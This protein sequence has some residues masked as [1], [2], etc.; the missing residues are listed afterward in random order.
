M[1]DVAAFD[2]DGTL[3]DGGSVLE[4]LVSLRGRRAVL[5]ATAGLAPRL[6][7]GAL[8]GGAAADQAK[9]RLFVRTLAGVPLAAVEEVVGPLRPAPPGPPPAS[10]RAGSVR[11]ASPA[12]R[13]GGDRV[14]LA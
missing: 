7:H 1:T 10:A 2:F 13:Q 11:L 5:L 8:V 9:Q 12:R 6:A 14:R 3:T 4:F